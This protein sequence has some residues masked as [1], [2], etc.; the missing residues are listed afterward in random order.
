MLPILPRS[1]P[2]ATT[3]ALALG[4]L[5]LVGA[6]A[7]AAADAADVPVSGEA[8]PAGEGVTVVVDFPGRDEADPGEVVVGCAP[9]AGV[10]GTEALR[11]AGFA[12]TRDAA[13]MICAIDDVPDPCPTEFEGVWW[14]YWYADTAGD[15]PGGWQAY[16]EGS[17][18]A[19]T[20]AG[21]VEGWRYADG[22]E[23]PRVDLAALPAGTADDATDDAATDDG[24]SA[25]EPADEP[26][27]SEDTGA[28]EAADQAD[29]SGGVPGWAWVVGGVAV[30]ALLGVALLA[31]RRPS[32]HGPAGQD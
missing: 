21:R 26:T 5:L 7:P 10:T 9:E 29:A 1:A 6:A 30:L 18:T 32:A 25:E 23:G 15:D 27:S 13:T 22:S 31:M 4:A 24:S 12:D 20:Q 17:D 8:C 19:L 28:A 3:A 14:S 2:R 16:G 11:A